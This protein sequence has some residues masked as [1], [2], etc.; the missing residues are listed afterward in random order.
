MEPSPP[1]GILISVPTSTVMM[2]EGSIL[3]HL[4]RFRPFI[5]TGTPPIRV[6]CE[7][8]LSSQIHIQKTRC[9]RARKKQF[10]LMVQRV[11]NK[12]HFWKSQITTTKE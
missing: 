8:Q 2:M 6:H 4:L 7:T 9:T 10:T 11:Q 3:F 5:R 1:A 12:G